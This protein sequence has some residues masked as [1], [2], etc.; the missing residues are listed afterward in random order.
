MNI[1]KV[2]RKIGIGILIVVMTILVLA[3]LLVI[4]F[5]LSQAMENHYR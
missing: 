3:D 2:L 5:L 1:R 4:S